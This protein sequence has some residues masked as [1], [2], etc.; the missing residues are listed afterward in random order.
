M[1]RAVAFIAFTVLAACTPKPRSTVIPLPEDGFSAPDSDIA[2]TGVSDDFSP[3]K[4]KTFN[5]GCSG[6]ASCDYRFVINTASSHSFTV[7][8]YAATTSASHATGSGTFY[9]HLQARDS[10]NSAL[11][12]S[13]LSFQFVL[14]DTEPTLSITSA[15]SIAIANVASYILE[16]ACSENGRLVNV[17]VGGVSATPSCTSLA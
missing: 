5:W 7:E 1:L 4:N 17:N 3:S 9:L 15:P 6:V 14:D 12:S 10:T 11:E 13:V 16:G 2:I 8:S